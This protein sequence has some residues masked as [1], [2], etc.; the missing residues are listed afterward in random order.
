MKLLFIFTHLLLFKHCSQLT[1]SV[2]L[3]IYNNSKYYIK[4]YIITINKVEYPFFNI[5]SKT[6]SKTDRLP[7]IYDSNMSEL[8][9]LRKKILGRSHVVR[10]LEWPVDNIG[11]KKIKSGKTTLILNITFGHN[12]L[13]TETSLKQE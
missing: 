11:D 13:K 6:Y 7:Y 9:I 8:T 12:K 2:D 1:D 4:K 5:A 10:E 3:R